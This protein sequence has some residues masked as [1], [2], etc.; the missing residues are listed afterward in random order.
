MS[1]AERGAQCGA[2][3]VKGESMPIDETVVSGKLVNAEQLLAELFE[4]DCK[5]SIR[6][7]RQQTKDKSI[8]YI[9]IGHLVFFD[10][11][12]VRTAL[13][14]KNL[15]RQRITARRLKTVG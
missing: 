7:L 10:T 15:V 1:R 6:W 5:P 14:G 12:M 8:P 3:V 11:D 13:A 4:P 9:R 2:S